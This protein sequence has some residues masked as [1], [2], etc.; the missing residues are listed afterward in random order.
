MK[1]SLG[2]GVITFEVDDTDI[3]RIIREEVRAALNEG[4][5]KT[6]LKVDGREIGKAPAHVKAEPRFV[7]AQE[8]KPSKKAPE[9]G[10]KINKKTQQVMDKIHLAYKDG[11]TPGSRK[12]LLKRMGK[13]THPSGANIQRIE[14]LIVELGYTPPPKSKMGRPRKDKPIEIEPDDEAPVSLNLNE[15]IESKLD[16]EEAEELEESAQEKALR[17][18]EEGMQRTHDNG[19]DREILRR[20][21]CDGADAEQIATEVFIPAR[22]IE[23][24]LKSE[25]SIKYAGVNTHMMHPK[26]RKMLE[27]E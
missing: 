17:R 15:A 12:E 25:K 8:Q 6:S 11:T 2:N 16:E 27:E 26:R 7:A 1:L 13:S 19:N 24:F 18:H 10:K 21:W 9:N 4:G 3:R 20:F 5:A 23:V 14:N 22:D